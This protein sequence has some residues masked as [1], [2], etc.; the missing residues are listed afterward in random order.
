MKELL[1][2]I[3]DGS[4][5]EALNNDHAKGFRWFHGQRAELKGHPIESAGETV[6]SLM[7]WLT[8]SKPR[9]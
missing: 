7:P 3:Q 1:D 4:F 8:D 2:R 5:A 6:R 9:M